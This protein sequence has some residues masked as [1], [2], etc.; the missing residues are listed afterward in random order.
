[1]NVRRASNVKRGL[2]L[3]SVLSV[4]MVLSACG[5]AYPFEAA[6]L[7]GTW[8][9]P[10]CEVGTGGDGSSFYYTRTFT[11]TETTWSIDFTLFGDDSCGY[12]LSTATIAGPFE[13]LELVEG[14]EGTRQGNFDG[15]TKTL[16]ANDQGMAD[17]FGMSGCGTEAWTVGTAQDVGGTGCAPLGLDSIEECPTEFDIVKLEG[18]NL[19][20]GDRSNGMCDESKRTSK[21]QTVPVVKAE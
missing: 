15:T 10:S 14:L 17:Y 4:G 1:M 12:K 19:Y 7:V 18:N 3:L 21:L 11:M 8:A 9:S 5:S 16:V 13:L 20:F 2:G 6:D